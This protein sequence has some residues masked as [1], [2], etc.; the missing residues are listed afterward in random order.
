MFRMLAFFSIVLFVAKVFSS[1]FGVEELEDYKRAVNL[2][3]KNAQGKFYCVNQL[4]NDKFEANLPYDAANF[5]TE[6]ELTSNREQP[7]LVFTAS[8]Q[9]SLL[10]KLS[11]TISEDRKTISAFEWQDYVKQL[12]NL[13]N[14]EKPEI[15]EKMI[16][17]K[18]IVC[19]SSKQ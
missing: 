12:V 8:K 6:G 10:K 9:N 4:N 7:L 19:T 3:A 2:A 11:I 18:H 16:L 14:L 5:A 15:V 17:E 1:P 13:G